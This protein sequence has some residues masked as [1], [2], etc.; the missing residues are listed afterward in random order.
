MNFNTSNLS[1]GVPNTTIKGWL[2]FSGVRVFGD[3]APF[4]N[5]APLI[6]NDNLIHVNFNSLY[7][8]LLVSNLKHNLEPNKKYLLS[9]FQSGSPTFPNGRSDVGLFRSIANDTP[10]P[11]TFRQPA[12][13]F[14]PTPLIQNEAVPPLAYNWE[15]RVVSF[16]ANKNYEA[17]YLGATRSLVKYDQVELIEDQ[18]SSEYITTQYTSCNEDLTLGIPLCDITG[19]NYSWFDVTDATNP[20]QIT[21]GSTDI[22]AND[23]F[24]PLGN[25][26]QLQISGVSNA[27][28]ELRRTF[29]PTTTFE[30]G[31]S[32][33]LSPLNNADTSIQITVSCEV[34]DCGSFPFNDDDL[35]P[36]IESSDSSFIFPSLT[37]D[38]QGNVYSSY[39]RSNIN[40]KKYDNAGNFLYEILL[41]Q[42]AR[43]IRVD[44]QDNLYIIHLEAITKYSSNGQFLWSA[45]TLSGN[46][47]RYTIDESNGEIYYTGHTSPNTIYR[48][49]NSGFQSVFTTITSGDYI[50]NYHFSGGTLNVF[51]KI[52]ETEYEMIQYNQNGVIS[53]NTRLNNSF[54]QFW[55][56]LRFFYG[57]TNNKII[58]LEA[59]RFQDNPNVISFSVYNASTGNRIQNYET[60]IIGSY[61]GPREESVYFD[62]CT[63]GIYMY[64][65]GGSASGSYG[66][67]VI[68]FV[69]NTIG[70]KLIYPRQSSGVDLYNRSVKSITHRSG[71]TYISSG[72][73]NGPY[74]LPDGVVLPATG[75]GHN[76]YIL[77]LKEDLTLA[78]QQ[79]IEEDTIIKSPNDNF[80][81]SPN[82][83]SNKFNIY[84]K[85]DTSYHVDYI[86][87]YDIYGKLR[88]R[89]TNSNNGYIINDLNKGIYFLKIF[90]KEGNIETHSIL[91]E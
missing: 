83:V 45:N 20:I 66:A 4:N 82:S 14:N 77:R 56:R 69:N 6:T 19:I 29:N 79:S 10:Y 16:P 64:F 52:S 49:S 25:G 76:M 46:I 24:S 31:V 68:T 3:N 84:P 37:M 26:S 75:L 32:T 63:E 87:I 60:S 36:V 7:P 8:V 51:V 28:F 86:E 33:L 71:R 88:Y 85:S 42:P 55:S 40:V 91:K 5:D 53:R 12:S 47:F 50:N 27:I 57:H 1:F 90:T 23:G 34:D 21:N 11:N 17:L 70:S 35:W 30:D 38:S 80:I 73:G 59:P 43:S 54:N 13:S 48:I 81:I 9:Y 18:L 89:Y 67:Y 44:M 41:N 61:L 58:S 15:Q 78:R 2:G 39:V 22:N 62:S 65:D 74:I 72:Y